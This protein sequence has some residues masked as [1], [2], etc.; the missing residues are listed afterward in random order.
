LNLELQAAFFSGLLRYSAAVVR[1]LTDKPSIR[2][3]LER[4]RDWAVY[5]LADLDEGLFEQCEW[6]ASRDALGLVFHGLAIR[7]IF[8]MGNAA[9][10]GHILST[11]PTPSGYLNLQP[12]ALEAATGVYAFRRRHEMCRMILDSPRTGPAVPLSVD[13]CAEVQAFLSRKPSAIVPA[14]APV[15]N[16][17]GSAGR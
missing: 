6:W 5:A 17:R 16:R 4:E 15:N 9:D 14:S 2:R 1:R 3:R 10:V 11:L 12:H 8:L 13:D 7:P